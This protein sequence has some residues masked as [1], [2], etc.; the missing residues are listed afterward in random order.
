M[1]HA[2]TPVPVV[3]NEKF[4]CNLNKRTHII[5]ITGYTDVSRLS[6]EQLT[7]NAVFDR[8]EISELCPVLK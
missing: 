8:I 3:K 7:W 6:C 2:S 4:R 1:N 5:Q